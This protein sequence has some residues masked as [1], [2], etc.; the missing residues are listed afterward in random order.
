MPISTELADVYMNNPHGI[1]F[2]E[3]IDIEHSALTDPLHYTN[4]SKAI[5][6][7]LDN[8]GEDFV[9]YDPLPFNAKLPDKN[10]DGTQS[11]ELSISNITTALVQYINIMATAPQEPM[12]LSYRV[13]LSTQVSLAGHHLN[14]LVPPWRYEVSSVSLTAQAVVMSATKVNI[15]NRSFPRV[16][17]KR[18]TFPGLAR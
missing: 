1:Y 17:Y 12:R 15:H 3:A 9:Q 10:T 11:L 4:A 13:F 16:R 7:L 18:T 8:A 14:Q 6:G 5:T 2:I